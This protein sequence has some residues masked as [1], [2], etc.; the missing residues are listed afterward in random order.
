MLG[1]CLGHRVL[2]KAPCMGKDEILGR[3]SSL[4]QAVNRSRLV[5]TARSKDIP[6]ELVAGRDGYFDIRTVGRD[7]YWRAHLGNIRSLCSKHV[8]HP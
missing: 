6:V 3:P 5:E 8:G 2:V 4:R 1:V 7:E